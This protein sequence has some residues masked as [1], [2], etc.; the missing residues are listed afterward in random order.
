MANLEQINRIL[1]FL[2]E[3]AL[4][5]QVIQLNDTTFLPGLRHNKGVLQIDVAKV[6]FPGDILHEAGH[7][8]VCEPAERYLLDGNIYKTGLQNHRPKQQMMGEEMAAT[9]WSVAAALYLGFP[10]QVVFHEAGYRGA[11]A[12][13]IEAFE[14]GGGI[15]HPLLGA[16]QMTCPQQGFPSMSTWI[17]TLSWA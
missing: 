17:R 7:Y 3:I 10:L 12:S 11:S 14:N 9:A 2:S 4:P 16:F 15:G 1:E 5:Y 8:A 6:Q 13:L